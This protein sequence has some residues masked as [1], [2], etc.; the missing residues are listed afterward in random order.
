MRVVRIHAFGEALSVDEVSEPAPGPGEVLF[1][2]AVIGVNPI[3]AWLTEGTV[4]GGRQ[5]LPFVPGADAAGMV[6]GRRVAVRGAGVGSVR[7]GLYRAWA[8]VPE[9]SVVDLPDAVSFEQAAAVGVAGTTAV[10]LV[11][12]IARVKSSDRTLVLGASGGVGSLIVQL[13]KSAGATVWGQTT[14]P[15]KVEFVREQGADQIVATVAAGLTEAARPFEPTVVFD[16]LGDGYTQAAIA[17]MASFGRLALFGTSAGAVASE[18]DLR[19]LYRKSVSIL[20]YS[21]TIEPPD[22]LREGLRRALEAVARGELR[23]PID[24]VLPLERAQEAH[25]RIRRREVQ[26]K[27]LLRP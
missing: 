25:D 27:L 23:V 8:N 7:D 4:A 20:A 5:T 9:E 15:G 14:D 11:E 3:D 21:G 10:R 26:G 17:A 2:A 6:E 1:E 22:V 24:D 12:D 18:F 19:A 16:P 13:A